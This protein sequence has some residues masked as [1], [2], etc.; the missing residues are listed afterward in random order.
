MSELMQVNSIAPS[1]YNI[2]D[3]ENLFA[4]AEEVEALKQSGLLGHEFNTQEASQGG[5]YDRS[6]TFH[7]FVKF[8]QSDRFEWK[9]PLSK[10]LKE[11]GY[12]EEELLS[13]DPNQHVVAVRGIPISFNYGFRYARNNGKETVCQTYK[14]IEKLSNGTE[15][16]TNS[17][18]PLKMPIKSAFWSKNK[19]DHLNW[20]LERNPQLDLHAKRLEMVTS[21]DAN[22]KEV[23]EKKWNDIRCADCVAQQMYREGTDSCGSNGYL[24]F[25]VYEVGIKDCKDH[26]N[27]PI[28]NPPLIR[29]LPITEAGL[30]AWNNEPLNH[31]FIVRLEGLGASQLN[32]VGPDKTKY[33]IPVILP[34][35]QARANARKTCYLPDDNVMSAGQFYNWLTAQNAAD[36][37]SDM[38]K[39]GN[40]LFTT[41]TE[42]YIAELHETVATKKFFP[43]FRPIATGRNTDY[44]GHPVSD[45]VKTAI[46]VLNA[47]RELAEAGDKDGGQTMVNG[48]GAAAALSAA[49]NSTPNGDNGNGVEMAAA[50]VQP[51]TN[52]TGMSAAVAKIKNAAVNAYSAPKA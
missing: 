6:Y 14:L 34:S 52:G 40:R 21:V 24:L 7:R 2:N 8:G 16:V 41:I 33:Q 49:P 11:A 29:W 19:P 38:S 44:H 36:G 32:D 15:R 42:L 27:D 51:Q 28:K 39:N 9:K 43:V 3:A 13:S 4:E 48:N 17:Q 46:Q 45:Y 35:Q 26:I 50:V 1:L 31:P 5:G 22:G 37:R 12:S 30:R 47:E 18:N 23:V 25:C 20:V 10:A